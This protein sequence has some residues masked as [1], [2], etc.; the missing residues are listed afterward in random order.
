M[1]KVIWMLLVGVLIVS[2]VSQVFAKLPVDEFVNA[3]DETELLEQRLFDL[4]DLRFERV[5]NAGRFPA[6]LL[7]VKQPINHEDAS[8]GHFYQQVYLVH[9][10]F[11]KKVIINTNGYGLNR[12]AT[13]LFGM[14]R[15][16]YISVEHRYFGPSTP[17]EKQWKFLTIQQAAA[18][19]HHVRELLGQIYAEDWV[20][21]GISKGG[22]TCTYYKYFYP[23]DVVLSVPYVAPFPK[24]V[25]DP[26]FYEYLDTVG[27][28]ECRDK[29]FQFQKN[30]LLHKEE[31]VPK[32]KYYLKG[33]NET[34]EILGGYEAALELFVLEYPFGFWQYGRTIDSI[35]D[36]DTK[37][38][39]LLDHLLDGGDYWYLL[40]QATEDM[41]AHYYQHA[42]QL[43]YYGYQTEPFGDLIKKWGEEPSACFFPYDD[44]L[45]YDST[46]RDNVIEWMQ[47]D[48]E[49]IVFIYGAVDTWT[50]AQAIIGD[51]TKVKKFVLPGKHHGSAR[52]SQASPS[53]RKEILAE[54]KAVL[55]KADLV[56]AH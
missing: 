36:A 37:P 18:D 47:T 13:E 40:D 51:N 25:K 19:Y 50:V 33:K 53:T 27:T 55:N 20:S 7:N 32:L 14:L 44:K 12:S 1:Q 11:G 52:I 23:D 54:I 2:N 56:E 15:A 42:T 4:P 41:A 17:K 45:A 31:L 35:P 46:I 8:Q 5:E 29:M 48:A 39:G 28:Q 6:Y 43:G 34:V 26:R 49:D 9:R 16:N 38:E 3:P 24:G 21:T 22:E 30:V 10:G